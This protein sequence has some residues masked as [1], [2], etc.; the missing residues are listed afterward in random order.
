M[1]PRK[2]SVEIL[3]EL[4]RCGLSPDSAQSALFGTAEAT[5]TALTANCAA[6]GSRNVNKTR[7]QNFKNETIDVAFEVRAD[8]YESFSKMH[9]KHGE[10]MKHKI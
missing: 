1:C 3:T 10:K 2:R 4:S 5:P 7:L 9:C 8:P 6:E